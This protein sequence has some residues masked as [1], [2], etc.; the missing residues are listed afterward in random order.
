MLINAS[1]KLDYRDSRHKRISNVSSP[2]MA[3]RLSIVDID[4]F[5]EVASHIDL[6][7][8]LVIHRFINLYVLLHLDTIIL[9]IDQHP[10]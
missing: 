7:M 3:A 8:A 5:S 10:G 4:F 9:D 6:G 1:W 2:S